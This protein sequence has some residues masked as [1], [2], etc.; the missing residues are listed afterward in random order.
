MPWDRDWSLFIL[1]IAENLGA[2]LQVRPG[3]FQS[4]SP[5]LGL[6]F[7]SFAAGG[8]KFNHYAIKS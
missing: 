5:G 2:D 6:R 3:R 8:G 7:L 4:E 1:D